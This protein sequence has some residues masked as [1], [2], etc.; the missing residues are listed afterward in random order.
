VE[1]GVP[2]RADLGARQVIVRVGD[3]QIL[4]SWHAPNSRPEGLA[5]GAEGVCVTSAGDVVLVSRDGRRWEFP[6]GRPEC[7]ETWE[8]TLRR[9]IREEACA[10]VDRARLLGFAR[11]EYVAGRQSG[12]VLVRSIWRADV[13]LD[14]WEPRHE[15]RFRRVVL[16]ADVARELDIARHPFAPMIRRTL[17]EADIADRQDS[18]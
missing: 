16:A 11:G 8:Q 15:I 5:H 3:D 9:E 7:D 18:W 4:V 13:S 6:A 2:K 12:C 14:P 10:T 17:R 1:Q